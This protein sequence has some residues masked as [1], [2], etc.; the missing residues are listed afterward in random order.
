MSLPTNTDNKIEQ[1]S[2]IK[3]DKYNYFEKNHSANTHNKKNNKHN[4]NNN[5]QKNNNEE[6]ILNENNN[7]IDTEIKEKEIKIEDDEVL[8]DWQILKVK[9]KNNNNDFSRNLC[10]IKKKKK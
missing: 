3:C 4:N 7:K 2:N 6:E 5:E 8:E 10:I 9:H 1:C